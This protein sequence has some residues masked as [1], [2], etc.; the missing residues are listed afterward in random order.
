MDPARAER[1]AELLSSLA[2]E[3]ADA[4]DPGAGV[5]P[6]GPEGLVRQVIF[7]MLLW[8]ASGEQAREALAKLDES[9][10]DANELRVAM[11][12]DVESLIGTRYPRAQERCERLLRGLHDIFRKENRLGLARV[13]ALSKRDGRAFAESIEALPLFVAQRVS[14]VGLGAHCVPVDGRI[15]AALA[16][17]EVLT[18]E[19]TPEQAAA[20]L[21]HAIRTAETPGAYFLLEAFA[22]STPGEN[23]ARRGSRR[24]SKK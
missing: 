8:E 9:F 20:E 5:V 12:D 7:S 15:A 19:Q 1:L 6:A 23:G 3:H 10:V 22:A 18:P 14:L 16:A 11:P 24:K 2:A 21:E 4:R 13:A 17:E